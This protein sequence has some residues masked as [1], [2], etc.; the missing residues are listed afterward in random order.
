MR[1]IFAVL[2]LPAFAHPAWNLRDH[3]P[4]DEVVVQSHRGAGVLSAENSLKAFEIAWSLGTI[5]EADLRT[6]RDGVI[7]AFHDNDFERTLPNAPP[8]VRRRRIE[9]LA[10]EELLKIDIGSGQRVPG[11]RDMFAALDR[12]TRR[13]LYI[14]I[15]NV[16]LDQLARE[17]HAAGAS[18]RLILA[19]TD[20]EL[21]RRWKRLA[22]ES[23]TLHWMG[24]AEEQL[25]AR[26]A[27]LRKT[28]FADITQL[29]IHVRVEGETLAPSP[30]FLMKAG[31]EL[32]RHGI[33]FQVLPWRTAD[34]AVF[35][36][37]MD[38]GVASFATDYPDKAMQAI[39]DYYAQRK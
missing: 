36:K 27:A 15:K 37:L 5:P 7:V 11:L 32:R 20:Y 8:E 35:W 25:A 30:R 39:R 19:S 10:W 14:D 3:I 13:K 6:T 2:L 16:D 18:P 24:G 26:L 29:Q 4:L 17:A 23:S 12:D 22:P 9:D 34:P 38:L 33:L 1:R 28:N 31:G 21:I